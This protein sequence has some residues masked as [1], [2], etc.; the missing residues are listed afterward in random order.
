[1]RRDHREVEGREGQ[2]P[3]RAA[4]GDEQEAERE[5]RADGEQLAQVVARLAR[6]QPGGAHAACQ[7]A[8]IMLQNG[9]L[10][11]SWR[12]AAS[13]LAATRFRPCTSWEQR[14]GAKLIPRA[15]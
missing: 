6:Q 12:S 1:M 11:S 9:Y 15:P 8:I 13:S 14:V 3:G 4:A 5:E 2:L 10:L 7:L